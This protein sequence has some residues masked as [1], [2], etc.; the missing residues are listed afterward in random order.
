MEDNKSKNLEFLKSSIMLIV[1]ID[2]MAGLITFNQ[3]SNG[4]YREWLT[5]MIN[6][7]GIL[8]SIIFTTAGVI[9]TINRNYDN[10]TKKQEEKLR[11]LKVIVKFEIEN[12]INSFEKEILIYINSRVTSM[13]RNIN[14]INRGI[15]DLEYF[16]ERINS[17]NI[18]KI[19][20][21]FKDY[22]YDLILLDNTLNEESLMEFYTVY[23][24]LK[25]KLY[26]INEDIREIEE[27]VIKFLSDEYKKLINYVHHIWF[28]DKESLATGLSFISEDEKIFNKE[29]I[30][31]LENDIENNINHKSDLVIKILDYLKE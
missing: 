25:K 26:T 5:L 18:Y 12:F 28:D 14:K 4:Y 27:P 7:T 21:K 23:N 30:K 17:N 22:I 8:L 1:C 15:Y 29:M 13:Y 6:L 10:E 24:L 19:D 3:F 11:K 16:G 2:V 20:N 31:K 9:L